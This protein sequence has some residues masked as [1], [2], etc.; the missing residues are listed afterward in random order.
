MYLLLPRAS[1]TCWFFTD[2]PRKLYLSTT[3]CGSLVPGPVRAL[4][5]TRRVQPSYLATTARLDLPAFVPTY[6]AAS[7]S[8]PQAASSSSALGFATKRVTTTPCGL[9]EYSSRGITSQTA[10]GPPPHTKSRTEASVV[11]CRPFQ[12]LVN[13]GPPRNR[14]RPGEEQCKEKY[15]TV[16]LVLYSRKN[17]YIYPPRG[18]WW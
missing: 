8:T 1:L 10:P 16:Y 2:T 14:G 12:A 15:N 18:Q 11:A 3:V 9:Y 7:L 5:Y 4:I 6:N 13:V 17:I